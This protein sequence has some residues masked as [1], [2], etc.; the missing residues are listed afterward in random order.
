MAREACGDERAALMLSAGRDSTALAYLLAGQ[1]HAQGYASFEAATYGRCGSLDLVGG[2]RTARRL[3]FRHRPIPYSD[4]TLAGEADFIMRLA[5]GAAGLQ[6]AHVR[7]GFR[8]VARTADIAITGFLGDAV[9][10]AHL[11][12]GRERVIF[13]WAARWTAPFRE[14][15]AKELAILR[16]EVESQAR[17]GD[18]LAP[19]QRA[20]LVD[21]TIR[22]ASWISETFSL[23]GWSVPVATPFCHRDLIRFLFNL[24]EDQ[25]SGQVLYDR[26]LA[27]K[28][29]Q[30]R[31]KGP[32]PRAAFEAV[33]R[34]A[35]S[36]TSR[37][38]GRLH[39]DPTVDWTRM[40][41]QSRDWL[42]RSVERFG[43]D[44]RLRRIARI[45]T[46]ALAE[47]RRHTPSPLLLAIPLMLR[48]S[49][50]S[51]FS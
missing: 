3:G 20:L 51:G 9:T 40:Q 29:S 48:C 38:L 32:D 22:Q 50:R 10:G 39:P 37:R 35:R 2:R 49:A 36:W 5:G 21:L 28:R 31:S 33:E 13:A 24:P 7:V 19:H 25:L 30:W 12:A 17:A 18:G 45:E 14:D 4:W 42:A 26:W 16:D 15:Y 43:G 44:D 23:C 6:T 27:Q 46:R 11:R 41:R 47:R 8:E 34:A 1:G